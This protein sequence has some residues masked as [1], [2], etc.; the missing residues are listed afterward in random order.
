MNILKNIIL[1]ILIILVG[2][3]IFTNN[4]IRTDVEAYNRKIDSLQNEIDSVENANVVLDN[5]IEKVD[6]ELTQ[7][8]TRVITINKNITELKTQTNEKVDA[9]NTYTPSE[10]MWFFTNRYEIGL[11]S[12]LK[13]SDSKISH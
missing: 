12:T 9:V 10:L 5:H 6:T 11:D 8:E 13:S 7:V 1:V 2:Y 4:S 3:N